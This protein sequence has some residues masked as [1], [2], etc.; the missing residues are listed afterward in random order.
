MNSCTKEI[1]K[2]KTNTIQYYRIYLFI[3]SE[4][5]YPASRGLNFSYEGTARA[6]TLP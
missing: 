4:N 5:K 3:H 1:T 2:E 6:N